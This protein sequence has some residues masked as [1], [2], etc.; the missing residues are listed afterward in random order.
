MSKHRINISTA[1][2][3]ARI[4]LG[5]ML[6]IVGVAILAGGPAVWGAIGAL[7][8]VGAGVDFVVTGATGYCPLYAKLGHTPRSLREAHR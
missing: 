1:E 4:V 5:A 8:L 3:A 6:G 7:L 2:R